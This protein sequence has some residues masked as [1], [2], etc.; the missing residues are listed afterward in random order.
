MRARVW[1]YRIQRMCRGVS[2]DVARRRGRGWGAAGRRY[3]GRII[4]IFDATSPVLAMQKF[5]KACHRKGQGYYVGEWLEAMFRLLD[6]Q[7]AVVFLWQNSHQGD[8]V[9]EWADV[10]ATRA[11]KTESY[12]AVPRVPPQSASM[13]ASMPCK[14]TYK[15]A[16]DQSTGVV[17]R[18]LAESLQELKF[19]V[20]ST[21]PR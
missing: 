6:R 2:G 20:S 4:I 12:I 11:G 1:V 21:S 17:S 8:P 10:L 9:N 14:S 7:E 13:T 15:F 3:V 19:T 18:K 5:R 16:I